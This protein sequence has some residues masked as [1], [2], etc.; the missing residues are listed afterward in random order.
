Y[1]YENFTFTC[2][3][4]KSPELKLTTLHPT[5]KERGL[6][7]KCSRDIKNLGDEGIIS[8]GA[9]RDWL[10]RFPYQFCTILQPDYKRL[11]TGLTKPLILNTPSQKLGGI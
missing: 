5:S 6:F 3:L 1:L 7:C 8:R 4:V 2:N 11:K 9:C 10:G